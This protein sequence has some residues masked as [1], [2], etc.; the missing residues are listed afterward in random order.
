MEY[1]FFAKGHPNVTSK[2]KTTFEVTKDKEIGKNADCI[3]GVAS[4]ESI[5]DIPEDIRKAIS[6]DNATVKIYL[7]TEN[8]FDSITGRG[9]HLLTLDHPTDIVCRKSEFVCSRTLMIK[10]DKAAND[11]NPNLIKDL[12]E[13]KQLKVKISVS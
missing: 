8:A 4:D 1:V 11:L 9:N 3:I 2:H 12:R 6:C 13:G 10:A 7:E 5:K